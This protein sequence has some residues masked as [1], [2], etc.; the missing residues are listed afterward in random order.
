MIQVKGFAW[1]SAV[2]ILVLGCQSQVIGG[3]ST[4]TGAGG[5]G[6]GVTTGP[7][8]PG[9]GGAGGG[10]TTPVDDGPA[11][12]MLQSQIPPV[13][14]GFTSGAGAVTSTGSGTGVDPNSLVLFVSNTAQSCG[15]PY[16]TAGGC[17][18]A[19][20]QVIITLAPASQAV[21]T[22]L[23]DQSAY[24]SESE[25]GGN[26]TCSGGGGSYWDGTIQVTAIDATHVDFTLAGTAQI[27]GSGGTSDGS[28]TAKRCP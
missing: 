19:T 3:G 16:Q 24:M 8:E 9:T 2:S 13:V 11:I 21:G 4:S 28:Y 10:T 17:A 7:V 23:L 25:P 22:Y 18:T 1:L 6:G 26:G 20:H 27:I 15:D 5:G 12:A 14:G